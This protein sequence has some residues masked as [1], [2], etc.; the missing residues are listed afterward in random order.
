MRRVQALQASG[1]MALKHAGARFPYRFPPSETFVEKAVVGLGSLFRAFGGALD[2]I[3]SMIQGSAAVVEH[4]AVI[5]MQRTLSAGNSS[6]ISCSYCSA[7]Q[8]G[9]GPDQV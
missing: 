8:S 7:T 9:L 3:G 5:L 1:S 4:G 2:E 6:E